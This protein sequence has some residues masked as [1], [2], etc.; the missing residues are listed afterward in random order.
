MLT[1]KEN[2]VME[3]NEFCVDCG[4]KYFKKYAKKVGINLSDGELEKWINYEKNNLRDDN[5]IYPIIWHRAGFI[6]KSTYDCVSATMNAKSL[7][8]VEIEIILRAD[9]EKLSKR[10]TN[11]KAEK[12]LKSLEGQKFDLKERIRLSV[13]ANQLLDNYAGDFVSN[14][15]KIDELMGIIREDFFVDHTQGLI[16]KINKISGNYAVGLIPDNGGEVIFD[17]YL[18]DFLR[19]NRVNVKIVAA[20]T[21]KWD[22]VTYE[23]C[24]KIFDD[25]E[26]IPL[27]ALNHYDMQELNRTAEKEKIDL[28]VAKGILN[29]ESYTKELVVPLFNLFVTKCNGIQKY[30]EV[31]GKRGVVLERKID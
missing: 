12:V 11:K 13:L 24:K 10:E 20:K 18:I 9:P 16:K 31:N 26:I 7:D 17:K 1:F 5:F 22:D 21:P 29:V 19:E 14:P 15:K 2:P 3:R 30:F 8:P 23:E 4:R 25:Y 28:Y 27:Y 6:S